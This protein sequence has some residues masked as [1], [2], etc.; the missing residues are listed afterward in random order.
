[1]LQ[2]FLVNGPSTNPPTCP[3]GFEDCW[4][5]GLTGKRMYIRI[6]VRIYMTCVCLYPSV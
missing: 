3:I 2:A 1:M 6:Y 5:W 4:A